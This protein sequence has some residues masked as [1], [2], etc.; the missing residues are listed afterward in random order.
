MAEFPTLGEH[1]SV[2]ECNQLDFLPFC[3]D[4]CKQTFCKNHKDV[5]LH[6]CLAADAGNLA[7][8]NIGRINFVQFHCS[9]ESCN[10]N[11]SV[12][13]TCSK[14]QKKFCLIHRLEVDHNCYAKPEAS[15][16]KKII[17]LQHVHE[18]ISN[19]PRSSVNN[20]NTPV[21][22]EVSDKNSPIANKVNLMKLKMKATGNKSIPEK[23]RVY[24]YVLLPKTSSTQE[25]QSL[26]FSQEWSVGKVIDSIANQFRLIN[27]NNNVM[28]KK[29]LLYNLNA[30]S[31]YETS[32]TLFML[33]ENKT[34]LN[35]QSVKLEYED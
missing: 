1:C 4:Y 15:E 16:S 13:I 19:M 27:N 5:S 25:A 7:V 8:N 20:C 33:L 2:R 17:Q 26:F 32:A 9:F 12:D 3:C 22:L 30:L 23:E 28:A 24:L 35:G 21:L 29:L 34:L 31:S 6:Q 14:C 18:L 10:R 11:E